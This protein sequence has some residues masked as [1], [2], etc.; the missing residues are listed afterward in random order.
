MKCVFFLTIAQDLR[1]GRVTAAAISAYINKL[2]LEK[3]L[4]VNRL[5]WLG[6][7]GDDTD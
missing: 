6:S 5:N 7:S 4:T 1:E 3:C 2:S